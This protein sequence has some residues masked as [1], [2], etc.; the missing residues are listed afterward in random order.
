MRRHLA[1]CLF[2]LTLAVEAIAAGPRPNLLLI[3]ADDLNADSQGWMG[4]RL[5]ATP[6]LDAFAATGFRFEHCHVTAPICQPSRSA[7]MTG[8]V[9]HRNGALGFN[10]VRPDVPTLV[11]L[12]RDAGYFTAAINKI[13]HMQPGG[14]F[15]W[16]ATA[17]GSGKNPL[18]IRADFERMLMVARTQGKPFFINANLTDP[19]RPFPGA[20]ASRRQAAQAQGT[21]EHVGRVFR[22]K[23]V[24]VPSFLEDIPPVRKELA[25][26]FT[27]V[28]RFDLGFGGLM[29]A[30]N[31]SGHRDDT[32]VVFLADNGMSFPFAK[33]TVYRH[34]TWA[35]VVIRWPGMPGPGA[36]RDALIS[37]VDLMPTILEL[38]GVA[39]C[40]GLD[41]RSLVPLLRG[42]SQDGRDHVVTHVNTISSGRSLTQRCVRTSGRSLMF[43][44]WSGG[45]KPFRVEAMNGLSFAAMAEAARSDPRIRARVEQLVHGSPLAFYDLESDPDERRNRINDPRCRV[46]VERLAGLLL[47][48]MKRTGDPE[49]PAFQRAMM[50]WSAAGARR[51]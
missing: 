14:K 30:L 19:H 49:L 12:L 7:L 20:V 6:N 39:A 44:A 24:V 15:P 25:Q 11:E 51:D 46:E 16:D 36:N 26:Y 37:S 18:A 50:K 1:G 43:H 27:G 28:A 29:A 40:P 45:E 8:R 21:D 31:E 5:G 32:V 33:A 9:P 10:P 13:E 38:L 2:A 17:N 23:D 48:E 34:G 41:G 22:P 42:E 3:T 35:P 47:A 4:S